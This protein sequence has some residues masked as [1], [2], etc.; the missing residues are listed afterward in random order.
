MVPSIKDEGRMTL[1]NVDIADMLRI[2]REPLPAQLCLRPSPTPLDAKLLARW[3]AQLPAAQ[4]RVVETLVGDGRCPTRRAVAEH[5][6]LHL[7]TVH[8]HL[9]RIK[10]DRPVLW[11]EVDRV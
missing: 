5:L 4:F 11:R 7:G 10:R 9:A 8:T 2:L 3:Q 6:G 1:S